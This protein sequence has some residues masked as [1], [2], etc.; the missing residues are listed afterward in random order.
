MYIKLAASHPNSEF[1]WPP[2]ALHAQHTAPA[3]C[4]LPLLAALLHRSSRLS[5][6]I[7]ASLCHGTILY[8]P[9]AS[10]YACAAKL[11]N[12]I[13]STSCTSNAS[14]NHSL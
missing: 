1:S 6:A 14:C 2:L 4:I 7:P 8:L 12:T 9:Q 10:A 3:A 5:T 11:S 13:T